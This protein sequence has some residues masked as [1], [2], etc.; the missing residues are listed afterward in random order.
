MVILDEYSRHESEE[1]R[2]LHLSNDTIN[3][4]SNNEMHEE[5]NHSI[6][7]LHLDR[8]HPFNYSA[9]G[10]S[11]DINTRSEGAGH[12]SGSFDLEM[13]QM[14]S[15]EVRQER[16]RL[17][18]EAI[19]GRLSRWL[20]RIIPV[21]QT[22]ERLHNGINTGRLVSNQPGRFIG[23][24]T[25]GV[26][27]NLM[28]KPDTDR[29]EQEVSPPLYEE[30]AADAAPEYWEST[31]ISPMY[32]DEVF[33][34]GLPVGSIANFMWNILV[35]IAFQFVGFI[36]CYLLHTSHASKQGA[37]GGIGI[38]LVMYG[39][40]IVPKNFGHV[41]QVPHRYVPKDPNS[42][43]ID[44]SVSIKGGLDSYSSDQFQQFKKV[45]PNDSFNS[46]PY[47]AYGTIALGLLIIIKLLVDYYKVK[48]L[49][50][51]MLAPQT[52]QINL[53]TAL[54]E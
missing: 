51:K 33:V 45:V 48:L 27:R 7:G 29:Q 12:E 42:Y 30:A 36:L 41:D 3:D 25:D 28:A 6:E 15:F 32:E 26:F 37:R 24:G 11:T 31:I 38:T 50:R 40:N 10:S 14:A 4:N 34:K 9:Q 43:D 18:N 1:P 44:K 46:A 22:Y 13:Q 19:G 23:Q 52:E 35:S 54:A 16:E 21:R 53:V 47:L 2:T 49:E 20:Q 8:D 5:Y 39:Y 17:E